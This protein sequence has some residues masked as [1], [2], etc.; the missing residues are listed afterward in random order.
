V[1]WPLPLAIVLSV[2]VWFVARR[3]RVA[4]QALLVCLIVIT[5]HLLST[6]WLRGQYLAMLVPLYAAL[7]ML[8]ILELPRALQMQGRNLAP[9][10][11]IALLLVLPFAARDHFLKDL[12]TVGSQYQARQEMMNFM[13]QRVSGD[14]LVFVHYSTGTQQAYEWVW[15]SAEIDE[16]PVVF[17]HYLDD[18]SNLALGEYFSKRSIWLLTLSDLN[19]QYRSLLIRQPPNPEPTTGQVR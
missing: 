19:Y 15:N 17:A 11:A 3:R 1:F 12:R 4:R 5:A 6:P 2:G 9:A 14:H 13:R 10:V 16:Q 18:K 7:L 8:C